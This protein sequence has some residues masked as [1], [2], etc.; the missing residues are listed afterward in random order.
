MP[1]SRED[2]RNRLKRG[3]IL[4]FYVLFGPETQLLERAVETITDKA[5]AAGDLRDFN[6]NIFSLNTEGNLKQALAAAEQLPMMAT[7]RVIRVT[8]IRISASGYRDT[9]TEDDEAVLSAYLTNP[10]PSSVV[11][12]V[13][14]ELNG[15]RKMGKFLREKFPAF[16]FARLND[17]ELTEW[18]RKKFGEAG[19][20]ID[21]SALRQ[22]MTRVGP[23]VRR[24]TNEINKLAAASMPS[25]AISSELIG[26]L[27]PH[28]RELDNFEITRYLAEGQRSKAIAA[29]RKILDDGVEPLQLL[30]MIGYNYRTL[31]IAKDMMSR[32]ADRREITNVIKMH[33]ARHEAFLRDARRSDLKT[34]SRAIRR[35]AKADLDIKTSKGGGGSAGARM[36]LE[37]LVCELAIT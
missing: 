30:G 34:L 23:D 37:M 9:V 5:F 26:S 1:F 15:V 10:S 17:S 8:D 20:Q 3:E 4:P 11:I 31:L 2:L 29:L 36:Q 25:A 14:D 35:V 24:L 27:V 12:F 19:V 33:P 21:E 32:G 28:S 7:R 18:A 16:E 22:F 13:A 6:E